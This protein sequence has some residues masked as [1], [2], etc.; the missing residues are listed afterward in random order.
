M[1][2][3]DLCRC[4]RTREQPDQESDDR[5]QH[6]Q[7]RPQHLGAYVS[8][9]LH[10][11]DQRPDVGDQDQD[12]GLHHSLRFPYNAPFVV[13]HSTAGSYTRP[14]QCSHFSGRSAAGGFGTLHRASARRK[15]YTQ[16]VKH[17]PP[18]PLRHA[19]VA[20]MPGSETRSCDR[21]CMGVP[22]RSWCAG[23]R[24]AGFVPHF[25]RSSAEPAS[26]YRPRRAA[27]C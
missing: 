14:V 21:R 1:V 26:N 24:R 6:D 13:V 7:H 11:V 17:N 10:D 25:E 3:L 2:T 19:S 12:P 9:R 16:F 20:T 15:N 27:R 22:T 4:A 8:A 18:V 23:D 5:Q